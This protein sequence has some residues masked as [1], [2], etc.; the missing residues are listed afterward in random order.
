MATAGEIL[1]VLGRY[2]GQNNDPFQRLS[3]VC[4]RLL[5]ASNTH[6][7]DT[8]LFQVYPDA[9]NSGFITLPRI[10]TNI[11]G[12]DQ[13]W[14]NGTCTIGRPLKIQNSWYGVLH[15]GT[16]VHSGPWQDGVVPVPGFSTTFATWSTPMRLQFSFDTT[17]ETAGKIIVKGTLT[18]VPCE[19][20]PMTRRE[21][22]LRG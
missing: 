12:A 22:G 17:N 15:G 18:G 11:L 1:S 5:K 19:Y 10:Y 8:V 16:G 3:L 21:T 7:K 6:C 20:I 4:E 13:M 9:T 14:S 2:V